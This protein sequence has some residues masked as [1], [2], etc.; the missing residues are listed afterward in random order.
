MGVPFTF[1]VSLASVQSP[2]FIEFLWDKINTPACQI[3]IL[4]MIL[5]VANYN[6][7]ARFEYNTH[8]FTKVIGK[9]AIYVYAVYLVL[10]A[11][12]RDHF[13]HLAV[14]PDAGS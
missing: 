7:T 4:A 9:N 10:S 3:A 1:D 14:A 2:D 13:I 8:G 6:F 5:H 11:L 12:V